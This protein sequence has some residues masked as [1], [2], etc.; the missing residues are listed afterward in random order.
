MKLS[1][2]VLQ[3]IDILLS[4]DDLLDSVVVSEIE[5]PFGHEVLSNFT[6]INLHV[7]YL[8]PKGVLQLLL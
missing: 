6:T 3:I 7:C 8:V 5:L 2:F 4:F 1:F